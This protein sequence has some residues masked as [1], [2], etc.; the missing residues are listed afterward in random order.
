M[1]FL[2]SKAR[3]TPNLDRLAR[4]SMVFEQ[5]YSQAPLTVASHATI[6]SG[7]YPQTHRAE[8]VRRPGWR[9]RCRLFQTCSGR[10]VIARRRLSDPSRSIRRTVLPPASIAVSQ[11]TTPDF[12]SPRKSK[13]GSVERTAEQVVARAN[14]WLAHNPKGPFFLWVHLN[15]PQA[16]ASAFLQCR[17]SAADAAVGKLVAALRASKLYDDALIVIAVRSRPKPGRARRRHPWRLSLR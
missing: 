16:A 11:S 2:G 17:S 15:D 8:R 14:A 1:G 4:Q 7:T 9:L 5:A 3:L 10:A 13:R 12:T 6:L